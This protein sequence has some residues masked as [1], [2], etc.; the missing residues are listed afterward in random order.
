MNLWTDGTVCN[1][2][3]RHGARDTVPIDSCVEAEICTGDEEL[4]PA[5]N[6]WRECRAKSEIPV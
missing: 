3:A 6:C 1:L 4:A 2:W 5:C